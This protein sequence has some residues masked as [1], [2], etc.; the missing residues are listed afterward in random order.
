MSA[1]IP[2]TILDNFLYNPQTIA[3]WGLSQTFT[4]ALH[5]NWPGKRTECLSILHTPLFDY[6]N[7]K[8]LCLF[9]TEEVNCKSTLRFQL[10]E[11][12]K[13]DG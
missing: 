6:I 4:P 13:N 5:N 3:N 2:T 7:K 11:D 12:Y 10:I 8:V 1:Y 9:F